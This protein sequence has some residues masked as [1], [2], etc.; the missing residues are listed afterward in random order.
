MEPGSS[1][2]TYFKEETDILPPSYDRETGELIQP[3]RPGRQTIR[4]L[5]SEDEAA[6]KRRRGRGGTIKQEHSPPPSSDIKREDDRERS[7]TLSLGSGRHARSRSHARN[8]TAHPR[9]SRSN[10]PARRAGVP[11]PSSE[12]SGDPDESSDDS[13]SEDSDTDGTFR[14]SKSPSKFPNH[15]SPTTRNQGRVRQTDD[16]RARPVRYPR[17]LHVVIRSIP[18]ASSGFSQTEPD[19]AVPSFSPAG[20]VRHGWR[21]V[22]SR[23]NRAKT[24][25]SSSRGHQPGRDASPRAASLEA[26]GEPSA[27]GTHTNDVR[28][29]TAGPSFTSCDHHEHRSPRGKE[30][31]DHQDGT[32]KKDKKKKKSRDK[33]RSKKEKK[34]RADQEVPRRTG[35]PPRLARIEPSIECTPSQVPPTPEPS[36]E[37]QRHDSRS[38]NHSPG[39]FV[40]SPPQPA[41]PTPSRPP[42]VSNAHIATIPSPSSSPP[43]PGREG[44][45]R[46]HVESSGDQPQSGGNKEEWKRYVDSQLGI[47]DTAAAGRERKH[48]R[49]RVKLWRALKTGEEL[50][51]SM[52]HRMDEM[53]AAFGSRQTQQSNEP[54]TRATQQPGTTGAAPPSEASTA[55]QQQRRPAPFQLS[56][57]ERGPSQFCLPQHWERHGMRPPKPAVIPN[58]LALAGGPRVGGRPNRGRQDLPAQRPSNGQ[59]SGSSSGSGQDNND[60][61]RGGGAARASG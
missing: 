5:D 53:E 16:E 18:S 47:R 29:A 1:Q 9:A 34:R 48:K 54:S 22:N 40:S 41:M 3:G 17:S 4:I 51:C 36:S 6:E 39:L 58:T 7:T 32:A 45:K 46:R 50:V 19:V 25:A 52:M 23:T 33:K 44:T 55:A 15:T 35:R 11:R 26:S 43:P 56:L 59:A 38:S 20:S 57:K 30:R 37:C 42:A 13:S 10:T 8:K 49:K 28:A 2:P 12:P 27:S 14:P 21:V 60:M 24:P 61:E 31:A